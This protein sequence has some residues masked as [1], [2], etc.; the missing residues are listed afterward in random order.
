VLTVPLVVVM[1]A[2]TL[3][4][5]FAAAGLALAARRWRL[6]RDLVASGTLAWLAAKVVKNF[7]RRGRPSALLHGVVAHGT[8]AAGPG[9]PSGHTAVAAALATAAG[10]YLGRRGRRISW[11][12]SGSWPSPG[13]M[14]VPIS[15]STR[16][17]A[18][19][20]DGS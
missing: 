9:F 4:A 14:S 8:A 1:Q 7:V 18:P 13:S 5:V 12:G 6:A 2:G 11:C 20:S 10:P 17:A 3:A 19:P 15:R 16:S